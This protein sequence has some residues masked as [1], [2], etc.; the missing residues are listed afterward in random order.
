VALEYPVDLEQRITVKLRGADLAR[1]VKAEADL[2][3]KGRQLLTLIQGTTWASKEY[4][5]AAWQQVAS[6]FAALNWRVQILSGSAKEHNRAQQIVA[7]LRSSDAVTAL[8]P[9]SLLAAAEALASS[10]LVIGVDSGLTHL[11]AVLGVPTVGL[12]GPTDAQRT[13]VRGRAVSN[14]SS[15]FNCAPCLQRTCSYN[16]QPVRL[17]DVDISP[18]CFAEL[19]AEKIVAAAQT[20]LGASE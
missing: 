9:G 18:P 17:G 11:A 10:D 16:G 14:L 13:G 12:F 7:N 20:L 8:A 4:P 15:N 6:A 3:S 2:N 1:P 5:L 19:S